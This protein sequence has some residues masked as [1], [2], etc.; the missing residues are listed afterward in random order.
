MIIFYSNW[1]NYFQ[2]RIEMTLWI[3]KGVWTYLFGA[4]PFWERG[5]AA[6][7][8]VLQARLPGRSDTVCCAL[9]LLDFDWEKNILCWLYLALI[10]L[11]TYQVQKNLGRVYDNIT[12]YASI[13]FSPQVFL[14]KSL[15]S[16]INSI[17]HPVLIWI[18]VIDFV[19]ILSQKYFL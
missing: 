17:T 8:W 3:L 12:T 13:T 14:E 10:G 15:L 16:Y 4:K 6:A 1:T 7:L 5:C 18:N 9:L 19:R 11:M 2:K